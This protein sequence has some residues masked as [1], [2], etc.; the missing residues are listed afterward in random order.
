MEPIIPRPCLHQYEQDRPKEAPNPSPARWGIHWLSPTLMILFYSI[1]MGAA[2]GHH[3]LCQ[4]IEGQTP[5]RQDW[6]LRAGTALATLC[7]IFLTSSV[8]IAFTQII[9]KIARERLLTISSLDTLF[10][11]TRT[12]WALVNGELLLQAKV[13]LLLATV[14]WFTPLIPVLAPG[15]LTVS[16]KTTSTK[17]M[18]EIPNLAI[19]D[20][21]NITSQAPAGSLEF[22]SYSLQVGKQ[23]LADYLGP[24]GAGLAIIYQSIFQNNIINSPSPC[25]LNCTFAQS[26]TA[27]SYKCEDVD[28]TDPEAPWCYAEGGQ[29]NGTYL[30]APH[31][32]ITFRCRM[33]ST[34][35]DLTRSYTNG[36]HVVSGNTTYKYPI[37]DFFTNWT[38]EAIHE[39]MLSTFGQTLSIEDVQGYGKAW[40]PL[41]GLGLDGTRFAEPYPWPTPLS[42]LPVRNLKS[43]LEQVTANITISMLAYPE[44]SYLRLENTEVQTATTEPVWDYDIKAL[45]TVYGTAMTIG[46]GCLL[47]GVAA[48][49]HNGVCPEGEFV[50]ILTTTRNPKLDQLVEGA[51][52]GASGESLERLKKVK[53]RFGEITSSNMNGR[54]HAAFGLED[55]VRPLEKGVPYT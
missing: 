48:I 42:S 16:L 31:E 28:P 40:F 17:M 12:P 53:L 54:R 50:S 46:L 43:L 34:Q 55:Q 11:A 52:L 7:K 18:V 39:V 38:A 24:S 45:L 3:V 4:A 49:V 33:W 35:F 23:V 9:W 51:C 5:T 1:A 30:D 32:N 2:L 21:S 29:P 13:A 25:G 41:T 19:Y 14:V 22:V 8:G 10:S 15:S 36:I 26:F 27:P 37:E 47:L 20:D 44:L 6:I